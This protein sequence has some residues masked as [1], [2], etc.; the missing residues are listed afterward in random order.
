MEEWGAL[1]ESAAHDVLVAEV[2]GELV[3]GVVFGADDALAPP[4]HGLLAKLYVRPDF[5]GRGIGGVLYENAI[6]QMRREGWAKLWL[7]VL[8]GNVVAR[9]MYERRG[10]LPQ[11]ER[12]TDWPGSGI[13]EIGYS[14]D[15]TGED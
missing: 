6:D 3:A 2:R 15:L 7:W 10:W 8:E 13:Y 11:E 12:R 14:L 9:R 4:G 5:F 1:V